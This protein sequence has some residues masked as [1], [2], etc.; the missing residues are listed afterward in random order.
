MPD[1]ERDTKIFDDTPREELEGYARDFG[2]SGAESMSDTELRKRL[3]DVEGNT[4]TAGESDLPYCTAHGPTPH[5]A[6]AEVELAAE[7]WLEAARASGRPI[8]EPSTRPLR[9]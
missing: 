3:R 1:R 7:G 5:E 4:G 6:L 9:A 8:P 2:I